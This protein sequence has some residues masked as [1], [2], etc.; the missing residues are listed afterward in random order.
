MASEKTGPQVYVTK[1]DADGKKTAQKKLT[2]LTR[3]KG[4]G[5]TAAPTSSASSVA[6]AYAPA[7]APTKRIEFSSGKHDE[8]LKD[9]PKKDRSTKDRST[10]DRDAKKLAKKLAK[11]AAKKD[12]PRKDKKRGK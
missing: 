2:V 12:K 11:K 4:N 7:A 6:I 5:K 9:K 3:T 10:K 1:I 8:K